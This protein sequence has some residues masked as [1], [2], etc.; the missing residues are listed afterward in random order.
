LYIR[1]FFAGS[2]PV[3]AKAF[4]RTLR[5]SPSVID[6]TDLFSKVCRRVML[7]ANQTYEYGDILLA[8]YDGGDFI[9]VR[10]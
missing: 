10:K 9:F 6:G 4:I 5:E 7:G 3:S 8:G 1:V 2:A